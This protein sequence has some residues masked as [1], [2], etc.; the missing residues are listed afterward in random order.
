MNVNTGE[1]RALT[2]QVERLTVIV[3]DQQG[4]LIRAIDRLLPGDGPVLQTSVESSPPRGDFATHICNAEDP[5]VISLSDR[6][7]RG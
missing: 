1:L 4:I 3:E 5:N 6:R 7:K 2:E